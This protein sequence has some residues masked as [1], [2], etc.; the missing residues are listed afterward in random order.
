[1]VRCAFASPRFGS[2]DESQS[3][4]TTTLREAA[5][6][7]TVEPDPALCDDRKAVAVSYGDAQMASTTSVTGPPLAL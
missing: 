5:G 7:G 1:M 2:E 6:S 3:A 4:L